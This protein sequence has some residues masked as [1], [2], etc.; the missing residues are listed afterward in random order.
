VQALGTG[1]S[2]VFATDGVAERV[3]AA[4]AA[5]GERMWRLPIHDE[6]REAMK[7]DVADLNNISGQRGGGAVYA[8]VF[9]REFAG[10]LP[11]A[12]LDIAGTAFTERDL[13]MGPKGGTGVGV[14]T[15]LHYLGRAAG[16]AG[17]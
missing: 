11:W 6:Y 13:P 10:G 2:G 16:R 4:S 14:R 17:G 5:A 9:L 1:V 12:H 7:G 15:L 8:A 3:L